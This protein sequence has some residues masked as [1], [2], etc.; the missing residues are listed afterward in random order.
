MEYSKI[1]DHPLIS[2]R[3]FF[4]QKMTILQPFWVECAGARLACFY[5]KQGS[6]ALTIV[7]FHGNGE[8]VADYLDWFP[9]LIRQMGCN[10]FL[11]E[12]RGYGG[13]TGLPLLGSMLDDVLSIITA[14]NQ[15]QNKIILFGRS[16]GSLFAIKAA[17]QFPDI[18]G[19]ILE[20]AIADPLERLLLRV[21]PEEME[22]T[23]DNL[24]EAINEAL[25]I[26]QIMGRY[27]NPSLIMHTR[28]D[29]LID[30]SHAERLAKWSGGPVRLEIFAQGN[31]NDIMH[32]NGPRYFSL[33]NEFID[34]LRY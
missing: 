22:T 12:Y 19:L 30:S 23:P 26:R 6:D 34:T 8:V 29:G 27:T 31:H 32:V 25:N 3:Y 21:H 10:P 24:A 11:A 33:I 1:L 20:S 18:A 2:Q 7:H 9:K 15:P 16:V 4:P 13:S 14:V 28:H 17:E 5:N